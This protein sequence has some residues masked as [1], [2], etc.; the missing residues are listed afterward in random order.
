MECKY[1]QLLPHFQWVNTPEQNYSSLF[2]SVGLD[3]GL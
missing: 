2:I 1:Q 3:P